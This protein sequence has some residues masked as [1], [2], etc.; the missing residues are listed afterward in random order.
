MDVV[1]GGTL[2]ASL[3]PGGIY[4]DPKVSL[5]SLGPATKAN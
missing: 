1:I 2:R 3:D 5:G 4:N